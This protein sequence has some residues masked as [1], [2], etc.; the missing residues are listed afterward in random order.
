MKIV[1]ASYINS[2]EFNNPV[3]WLKRIDFVTCIMEELAKKNDVHCIERISYEGELEQ[4]GVH[5]HFIDLKKKKS[6]LPRRIH[7]II[8][9]LEPDIIMIYGNHSRG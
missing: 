8:S 3:S 4:E 7:G 1:T 6:Y 9:K 2:P 5:Y